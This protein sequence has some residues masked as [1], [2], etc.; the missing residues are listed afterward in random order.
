M[1]PIPLDSNL[2]RFTYSVGAAVLVGVVQGAVGAVSVG[3]DSALLWTL[4]KAAAVSLLRE[5][6]QCESRPEN[7]PR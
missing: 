4:L 6:A 1:F 5:P 3:G 7:S 2:W